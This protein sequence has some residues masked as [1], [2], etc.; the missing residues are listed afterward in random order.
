[1]NIKDKIFRTKYTAGIYIG[2]FLI[3]IS[4]LI[5]GLGMVLHLL[6]KTGSSENLFEVLKFGL[7]VFPSL[8][9][10]PLAILG[11]AVILVSVIGSSLQTIRQRQSLEQSLWNKT[12]VTAG[13]FSLFIILFLLYI[14]KGP[15]ECS[16]NITDEQYAICL[17][18]I[19]ENKSQAET[20]AW[21]KFNAYTN[22]DIVPYA[23]LF[24]PH[25]DKEQLEY[26]KQQKED[27]NIKYDYV[28]LAKR[29]YERSYSVPYGTNFLRIIAPVFPAPSTFQLRLEGTDVPDRIY[30]VE[31]DWSFSFL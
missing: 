5:Y 7:V 8:S 21:L 26:R 29:D 4:P 12:K 9:G 6:T 28:I 31:V 18:D 16:R 2:L 20:I 19:F 30:N 25:T 22:I 10:V 11:S 3:A 14:P 24:A 15:D 1:M 17:E 13:I 27:S 23:Q